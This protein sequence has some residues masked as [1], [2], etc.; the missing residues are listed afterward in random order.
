MW[1][2]HMTLQIVCCSN[3]WD[4]H[5]CDMTHSRRN[6][7]VGSLSTRLFHI[8]NVTHPHDPSNSVSLEWPGK[9]WRI[10]VC[11]V[12]CSD[13]W[14]DSY[15][16]V[17]WL[18]YTYA[19]WLIHTCDVTC[20]YVS[21]DSFIRW[22]DFRTCDASHANV[23]GDSFIRVTWRQ[24]F[25]RVMWLVHTCDVTH[26]NVW[27]W[28]SFFQEEWD[29][30][31][32]RL[33]ESSHTFESERVTMTLSNV[34]LDSFKPWRESPQSSWTG[35]TYPENTL[36]K[37]SNLSTKRVV[38]KGLVK[39]GPI[40]C[41]RSVFWMCAWNVLT[42]VRDMTPLATVGL[43]DSLR[44]RCCFASSMSVPW[45]LHLC[46]TTPLTA[47]AGLVCG[48]CIRYTQKGAICCCQ[49]GLFFVFGYM[50]VIVLT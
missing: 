10:Y 31:R 19:T 18:I 24:S 37:S 44:S 45:L 13:L 33:N 46:N 26:A 4:R 7:F 1:L 5:V 11:N 2:M 48:L 22:L 8:S 3:G 20:P 9:T 43:D 6:S 28:L 32:H 38:K 25:K 21:W 17:T 49:D 27:Q 12:T 15:T 30:F 41:T 50:C 39:K 40:R 42:H 16:C 47:N 14:D 29:D 23:P 36:Q 34:W 35:D